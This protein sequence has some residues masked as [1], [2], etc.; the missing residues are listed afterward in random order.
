MDLQFHL[1]LGWFLV[2]C[3]QNSCPCIFPRPPLPP[4]FS[5]TIPKR[6]YKKDKKAT[7]TSHK[8]FSEEKQAHVG[9]EALKTNQTRRE[10]TT[11]QHFSHHPYILCHFANYS[12]TSENG[13]LLLQ[14]PPRCG[15]ESVVPN[16]FLYYSI[17]TK[18]TSILR[19]P[20]NKVPWCPYFRGSTVYAH[21]KTLYM[22]LAYLYTLNKQGT[23][24]CSLQSYT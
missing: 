10:S 24:L 22:H 5:V 18:E 1:S 6:E 3:E 23:Q 16:Y 19:T 8:K 11:P 15:Q 9:M 20:P 2:L 17:C 14:K 7:E 13:F 21:H 4:F 12:G